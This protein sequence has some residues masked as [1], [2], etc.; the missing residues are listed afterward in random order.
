MPTDIHGRS[1]DNTDRLYA[2]IAR[3]ENLLYLC[4]QNATG[5]RKH[6][7]TENILCTSPL[8]EISEQERPH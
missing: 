4:K 2:A 7:I 5:Q 1:Y 6:P 8:Q 3:I